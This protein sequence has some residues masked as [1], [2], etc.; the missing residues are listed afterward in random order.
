MSDRDEVQVARW[1]A[2]KGRVGSSDRARLDAHLGAIAGIEQQLSATGVTCMQPTMPAKMDPHALANFPQISQLQLDLMLLAQVC[3]MTRV[4]TLMWANADSWQFFPWIGVN[5][6][7][8]GLSH[9]ADSDTVATDKLVKINTWHSTQVAYVLDKLANTQDV[10]GGTMLD[11]T[12]VLWGNEL[13]VGNNHT[14]QNIPWVL[15]GGGGYFK[16]GRYLQYKDQPHNNLLV[17]ICQ[18][19]GLSDVTTFGI[20]ELCTGPLTGLTA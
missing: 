17:S 18:A 7:H 4:S 9:S 8:H 14:Y 5:E 15:A 3:G 2:I 6:E 19:M 12:V 13:G 11:S 1:S 10:G 20:P 16:T